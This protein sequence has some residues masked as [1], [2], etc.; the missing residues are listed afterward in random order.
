MHGICIRLHQESMNKSWFDILF[1]VLFFLYCTSS[2]LVYSIKQ[3]TL[4]YIIPP[5][6]NV[7]KK[8]NTYFP[9]HP[10]HRQWLPRDLQRPREVHRVSLPLQQALLRQ[11]VPVRERVRGWRRLRFLR[12]MHWHRRHFVP[13]EAVL[14]S[15]G[16]IRTQVLERWALIP[17]FMVRS[18]RTLLHLNIWDSF[19]FF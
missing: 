10:L 11:S 17:F 19:S 8:K 13:Q 5:L 9:S 3:F 2:L 7:N 6:S 16:A 15:A 14:L 4:R 1:F 18:S 12:Q